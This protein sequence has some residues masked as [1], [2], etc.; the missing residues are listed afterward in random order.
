MVGIGVAVVAIS[1]AAVALDTVPTFFGS[2]SLAEQTA[3]VLSACGA[4]CAGLTLIGYEASTAQRALVSQFSQQSVAPMPRPLGPGICSNA[5]RTTAEGLVIDLDAVH[6]VGNEARVCNGSPGAPQGLKYAAT[7][8]SSGS[9]GDVRNDWR[10]ALRLVYAGMPTG[11]DDIIFRDCNSPERRALVS[12]WH[13]LFSGDCSG[14]DCGTDT[15]P[16]YDGGTPATRYDRFNTVVEP[17][18]RHAFRP[19]EASDVTQVFLHLLRLPLINYAQPAPATRGPAFLTPYFNALGN[20]PFCNVRRPT[21]TYPPVTVPSWTNPDGSFKSVAEATAAINSGA[22]RPLPEVSTIATGT[23]SPSDVPY[24]GWDHD[25]NPATPVAWAILRFDLYYP[26]TQ[27]QDPIRRKC[28]GTNSGSSPELGGEQV[29]SADAHLGLVLPINPPDLPAEVA[30]PTVPCTGFAFRT[31][32]LVQAS[33][34]AQYCADGSPAIGAPAECITPIVQATG[35]TNCVNR[36]GAWGDNTAPGVPK[37]TPLGGPSGTRIDGRVYNL[38]TRD[39]NGVALSRRQPDRYNA[40]IPAPWL[41]GF[42][43]IH[44]RKTLLPMPEATSF[45]CRHRKLSAQLGCLVQA[46]PCS[47]AFAGREALDANPD[48]SANGS[49]DGTR[50]LCVNGVCSSPADPSTTLN[51]VSGGFPVNP[52]AYKLYV[53]TLFGFHAPIDQGG[54]PDGEQQFVATFVAGVTSLAN[55]GTGT[56]LAEDFGLISLPNGPFC[57][58]FNE[59][60]VCPAEQG[61]TT[62]GTRTTCPNPNS[63]ACSDVVVPGIPSGTARCGD[64]IVQP[65]EECDDGNQITDTAPAAADPSDDR[66]SIG[67]LATD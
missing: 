4:D 24:P 30:Y 1:T 47:I 41:S 13:E 50:A 67:C 59:N 21:D 44:S 17:G 62:S 20:S 35:N 46:S 12:N 31:T 45:G 39:A 56:S 54:L 2:E 57:E 34:I 51:L 28:A 19:P 26:D 36:G 33:Q 43:R 58:D 11:Q 64:G 5:G 63:S 8:T 25:N 6:V 3:D 23:K 40:Q 48:F 66:C 27:D 16:S 15:H 42:Y 55:G 10:N 14:K 49:A 65:G 38:I 53:N 61:C 7:S 9:P 32:P 37:Y 60:A 52:L 18:L 22:A 29:C